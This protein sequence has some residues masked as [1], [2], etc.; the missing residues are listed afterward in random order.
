[1]RPAWYSISSTWLFPAELYLV[2]GKRCFFELVIFLLIVHL[3]CF[4]IQ[5]FLRSVYIFH[6]H[7]SSL[8]WEI[9]IFLLL[10]FNFPTGV[11]PFPSLEPNGLRPFYQLSPWEYLPQRTHVLVALLFLT[12]LL[13]PVCPIKWL[14]SFYWRVPK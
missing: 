6:K 12:L 5:T 2:P 9:L 4:L 11:E 8:V 13:K 10:T 7:Y 1:M 3:L 14:V